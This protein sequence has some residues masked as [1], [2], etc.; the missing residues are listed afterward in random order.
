[1]AAV[2]FQRQRL[3]CIPEMSNPHDCYAVIVVKGEQR[4]AKLRSLFIC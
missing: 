3:S 4:L 2:Q 1:M